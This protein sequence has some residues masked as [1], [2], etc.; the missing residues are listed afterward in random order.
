[1]TI[2]SCNKTFKLCNVL[3]LSP[4]SKYI[5]R[6]VLEWK[7]RSH[8]SPKL[9]LFYKAG[10]PKTQGDEVTNALRVKARIHKCHA[11]AL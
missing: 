4:D 3:P 6:I 5:G 9:T 7:E 10:K 2:K 8:L 11:G 1:M